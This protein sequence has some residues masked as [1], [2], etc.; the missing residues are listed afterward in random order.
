VGGA[1]ELHRR[2]FDDAPACR[3][4]LHYAPPRIAEIE[5]DLFAIVAAADPNENVVVCLIPAE[6][7]G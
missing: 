3:S 5:I 1:D 2:R 7:V 6:S 4:D